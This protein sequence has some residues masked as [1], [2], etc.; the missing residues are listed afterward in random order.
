VIAQSTIP[1]RDLLD[2]HLLTS[3]TDTS[4]P[5]KVDGQ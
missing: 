1:V 4:L 2:R 5:D 3:L